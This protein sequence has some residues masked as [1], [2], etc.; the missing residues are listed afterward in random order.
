MT[1]AKVN[2]AMVSI[3]EKFH[4]NFQSFQAGLSKEEDFL[5]C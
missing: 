2:H 1:A 5:S 4:I 3:E